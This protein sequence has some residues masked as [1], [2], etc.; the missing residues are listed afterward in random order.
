MVSFSRD[1]DIL[2]Y[3]PVLFGELGLANQV[4]ISGTGGELSG[5]TLSA[6]GADFEAVGVAAG[7]VVYLRS[8]DGL[9]D[10]AY[11]V[12]SIDSASELTVSVV[13]A[14]SEDATVAPPGASDVAYEVLTYRPQA[15]EVALR[16]TEYLGVRPGDAASAIEAG[17]IIESESLRRA[18]VFA[19]IATVYAIWASDKER[20]EHFWK[21][22]LHYQQL[23][24]KAR[25]R[26]RV[27]I[28]VTGDGVADATRAA[29][30][31]RLV[32]E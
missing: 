15:M 5:T 18:S 22:S 1:V 28:D 10:G 23:F 25:E 31:G 13:R 27:A 11:E 20:Q 2:K 16:L 14:G 26:C 8:A 12:V 3:E 19:V 21:K 4:L 30:V 7:S 32:R 24:E 6:A 9:L 29:G 17:Q